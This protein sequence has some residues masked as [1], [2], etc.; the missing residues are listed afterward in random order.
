MYPPLCPV[1]DV[2]AGYILSGVQ[3]FSRAC[4]CRFSKVASH[5]QAPALPALQPLLSSAQRR[6]WKRLWPEKWQ[7]PSCTTPLTS[8]IPGTIRPHSNRSH[9]GGQ[10]A[11]S[12]GS[13][14]KHQLTS[15]PSSEDGA[16]SLPPP[17]P[18]PSC[19][20]HVPDSLAPT[21]H[22]PVVNVLY[23][24]TDCSY[25]VLAAQVTGRV[26]AFDR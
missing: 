8:C 17:P 5:F 12:L 23:L 7:T 16:P 10:V 19:G 15:P 22:L 21:L 6:Y 20:P 13:E 9:S 24:P 11:P 25:S 4:D 3:P 1:E 2:H 18:T 14:T 26:S